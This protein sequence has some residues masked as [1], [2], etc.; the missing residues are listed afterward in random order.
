MKNRLKKSS[1]KVLGFEFHEGR[2]L[3][4]DLKQNKARRYPLSGRVKL[5]IFTNQGTLHVITEP[6]FEF[7]G[8][9]GP[10]IVDWY[11]PNLG[12]LYER[13]CWYVHDCN[14]YGLDLSFSDTN[15]L[16]YAM[17]R[18]LAGYRTTKATTIQLA[19]SLSKSWYGTPKKD[20]W[21]YKNIGKVS[22][23]WESRK[24]A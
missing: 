10:S 16:L 21:C 6:G 14:G 15:V 23:I 2:A 22:T 20:D 8:R 18:D 19:V 12:T 5:D 17:L 1:L 24:A 7:D 3:L 13:I 11:T 9:S 4:A